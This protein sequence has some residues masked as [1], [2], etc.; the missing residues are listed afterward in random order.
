M[1]IYTPANTS[2]LPLQ[3]AGYGPPDDVYFSINVSGY[4]RCEESNPQ[5][6]RRWDVGNGPVIC[7]GVAYHPTFIGDSNPH[8][9][10]SPNK[11]TIYFEP[12]STWTCTNGST[13][14]GSG[15]VEFD[16]DCSYDSANN[17]TCVFDGTDMHVIPLTAY[18]I[19]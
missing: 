7:A 13:I 4:E 16:M 9:D 17:A 1:N 3:P 15:S 19:T 8:A 10:S 11:G 2:K 12:I 18:T 14:R 5:S 6:I